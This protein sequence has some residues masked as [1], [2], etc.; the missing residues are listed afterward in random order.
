M[1]NKIKILIFLIYFCFKNFN[2]IF[3]ANYIT[4]WF[5]VRRITQIFIMHLIKNYSNYIMSSIIL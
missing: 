5:S 4:I 2:E 1:W 3:A